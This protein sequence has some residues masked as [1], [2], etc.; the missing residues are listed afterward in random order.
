[1]TYR[2]LLDEQRQINE[3]RGTQD[4]THAAYD[5]VCSV[6]MNTLVIV[7]GRYKMQ[8]F[9]RCIDNVMIYEV[10]NFKYW[11]QTVRATPRRWVY[12]KGGLTNERGAVYLLSLLP[13]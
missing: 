2:V 12:M 11:T 4:D 8:Y 3:T 7:R 10:Y 6:V 1:M 13:E 9:A 5:S